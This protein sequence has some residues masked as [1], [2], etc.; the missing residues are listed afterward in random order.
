MDSETIEQYVAKA[1]FNAA[2]LPR[3][4]DIGYERYKKTEETIKPTDPILYDWIRSLRFSTHI[5][6]LPEYGMWYTPSV[7]DKNGKSIKPE[8]LLADEQMLKKYDLIL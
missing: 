8:F 5:D 6:F 1:P 4:E 2:A 7:E 3:Y